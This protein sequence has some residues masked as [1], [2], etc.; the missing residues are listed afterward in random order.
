MRDKLVVARNCV[1][2]E[3]EEAMLIC[4]GDM[5]QRLRVRPPMAAP[6]IGKAEGQHPR[7]DVEA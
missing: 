4:N 5:K 1:A 3:T 2:S 7:P 6:F